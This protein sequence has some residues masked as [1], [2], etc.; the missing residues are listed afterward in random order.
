[1]IMVIVSTDPAN[2]CLTDINQYY[3]SYFTYYILVI[4]NQQL[5]SINR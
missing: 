2:Q 5:V 4:L 1:M 3:I